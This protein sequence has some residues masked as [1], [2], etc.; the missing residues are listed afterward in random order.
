M[1]NTHL[2]TLRHASNGASR[3]AG[4][5]PGEISERRLLFVHRKRT[6]WFLEMALTT[7]L[8]ILGL[9]FVLNFSIAPQELDLTVGA[10][11]PRDI[12]AP[13][14]ISYESALLT[15]A[16]RERAATAVGNVYTAPDPSITRAQLNRAR[17]IVAYIDSVRH[18]DYA[19]PEVKARWVAEIPD[20]TL[21]TGTISTVISLEETAWQRVVADVYSVLEQMFRMDIPQGRLNEARTQV[22][23]LVSYALPADQA[24]VVA[25]IARDLLVPNSFLD[26]EATEALRQQARASV[27]PI[28]RTIERG[29]IIVRS[30]DVVTALDI[31]ELEALGLLRGPQ[32][33][34]KVVGTFFFVASMVLV[35][36][37]FMYRFRPEML[38]SHKRRVLL[39]LTILSSLILAKAMIPGHV[40]LPYVFPMAAISMLLALLFDISVAL[41][42]TTMLS[43]AVGVIAGSSLELSVYALLGGLIGAVSVYQVERLGEFVWAAA[44]V[45]LANVVIGLAFR[46]YNQNYDPIGLLQIAGAGIFNGALSTSLAFATFSTFGRVFG[47]TT[48]LQLLEMAR[49]TH[50]LLRQLLLGAPGT[51]HHSIIVGNLA[52]RAA[53]LVGADSLLA[54]V[55]AYYHDIGKIKCPY[56]FAENQVDGQSYHERLDARTSAQIIINHVRDGVELGRKYGLP[57]RVLDIIAEHHGT[58][59][60][61]YGYFYQRAIEETN[62]QVLDESDF[63]YGGPRPQTK[64]AA[65][66]MLADSAEAAVRAARPTSPSEVE[67]IVRTVIDEKLTA[68]ELDQCDLTLGNLDSIRTAFIDVLVGIFHPRVQYP[69][70]TAGTCK[71]D[72]GA[73]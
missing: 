29:E 57:D 12:P 31:E 53:E 30:G 41:M 68:G 56:F 48:S 38:T 51:Y 71:S 37:V 8:L 10:V 19:P 34:Q 70:G 59:T 35:L 2:D 20:L 69:A 63:H 17:E 27:A 6:L 5:V 9:T 11:A 65:I 47:I 67:R 39:V 28:Q 40:V 58:S 16:E 13:R 52:E 21:S 54:R 15:Q 4:I 42:V 22:P 25:E 64:E 26:A 55:G 62:G 61:S 49:P 1:G 7:V 23:R 66:V 36:L 18:D 72:P 43:F 50:P 45:A 32:G 24:N 33:W 60:V 3:T 14:R 46:L 73:S 44:Y